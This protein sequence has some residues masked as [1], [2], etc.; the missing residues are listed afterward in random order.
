MRVL[1]YN[2]KLG[3]K[4]IRRLFSEMDIT[5]FRDRRQPIDWLATGKY[6]ICFFCSGSA[7]GRAQI[8]GLP[9]GEFGA[10]KEGV[11][12]T[13]S[14][15][16]IVLLNKAPHPN[17]A[18]VYINWFLSREGQLTLQKAYSKAMVDGSNS[19]RIDIPKDMVPPNQRLKEGVTYIDAAT[20]ERMSMKPILK[21][22]NEALAKAKKSRERPR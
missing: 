3:P 19:L 12:I 20:P 6:P 17:A 11:G 4:Y 1:Y 18:K 16:N 9:I 22:F 15:G 14:S 21:V 5:L 8:Q 10:M 2:P 13:S 7:I